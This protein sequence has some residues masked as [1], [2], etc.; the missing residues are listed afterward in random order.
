M[1]L[2]NARRANGQSGTLTRSV[3]FFFTVD[4]LNFIMLVLNR[5]QD[6]SQL[7][8]HYSYLDDNEFPAP[9]PT[10]LVIQVCTEHRVNCIVTDLSFLQYDVI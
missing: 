4:V 3:L 2:P 8:L 9:W 1:A 7:S 5:F 6:Q 10:S